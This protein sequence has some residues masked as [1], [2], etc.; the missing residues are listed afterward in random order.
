MYRKI[1]ATARHDATL[2]FDMPGN[3]TLA[4]TAVVAVC[5]YYLFAWL[6]FGRDPKIG[7]LVASYE[8]PRSLSP[9]MIRY[10]W[11]Q[12]FDDRT[13]W[14]GILSLVAKGLATMQ[15]ENGA[16]RLQP[17]PSANA[18]QS[19]P[20]EEQ[21]LLESL[22]RGKPRKGIVITLLEPRTALAA[23]DMSAALHQ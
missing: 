11:K 23:S 20:L 17:H 15:A 21:I 6:L 12:C 10:V 1:N 13:F 7:A 16:T 18:K 22:L 14:A 2:G 9:A 3:V 19:L 5:G 8:P 4:L